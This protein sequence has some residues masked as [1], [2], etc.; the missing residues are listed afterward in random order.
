[1]IKPFKFLTNKRIFHYEITGEITWTPILLMTL[2]QRK[3]FA[4]CRF[5]EAT[6]KP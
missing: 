4:F 2:S 6:P 5:N 1:M 3:I